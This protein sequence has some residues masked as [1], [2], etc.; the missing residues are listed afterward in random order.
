MK[1]KCK[2]LSFLDIKN[3]YALF[4][5]TIHLCKNKCKNKYIVL[6]NL[7]KYD[8]KFI[9]IIDIMYFKIWNFIRN[10]NLVLLKQIVFVQFFYGDF[11]S[12]FQFLGKRNYKN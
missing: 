9:I 12:S 4:W 11:E 6:I 8:I 2:A 3:I 7:Y 10:L 1:Y 5:S